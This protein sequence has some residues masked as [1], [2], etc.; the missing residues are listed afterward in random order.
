M[1]SPSVNAGGFNQLSSD[2]NSQNNE[3]EQTNAGIV[4]QS[5]VYNLGQ[6]SQHHYGGSQGRNVSCPTPVL[7]VSGGL[8]NGDI[9][10]YDTN[11][12]SVSA[13]VVIPLAGKHGKV[14][15]QV[16]ESIA[17]E[18]Q[19]NQEFLAAN[20]CLELQRAGLTQLDKVQYPVL[21]KFCEG[22]K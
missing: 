3:T 13:A 16:A 22:I 1:I 10:H 4:Q 5:A 6:T 18:T 11:G 21:S 7:M 17:L 15:R 12:Y 8:N 20:A 14:C 19:A 9:G 2:Q